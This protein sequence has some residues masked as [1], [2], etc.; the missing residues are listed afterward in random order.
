VVFGVQLPQSLT[1]Y[2]GVNGGGGNVSMAQQHLHRPQISA[3]VQQ[4]RRKGMAQR[5]G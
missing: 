3:V 4:V 2:V 5:V 1:G